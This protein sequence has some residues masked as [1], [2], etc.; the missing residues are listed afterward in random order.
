MEYS[1][2]E[3][4][5]TYFQEGRFTEKTKVKVHRIGNCWIELSAPK[6]KYDL[7]L[8]RFCLA[9]HMLLFLVM[10]FVV[11]IGFWDY[12]LPVRIPFAGFGVSLYGTW[13][14]LQEMRFM[15]VC[16]IYC[17]GTDNE[18]L[19]CFLKK[20]ERQG[21][22]KGYRL[23]SL[24]SL[25]LL[26]FFKGPYL[27]EYGVFSVAARCCER[28]PDQFEKIINEA[29]DREEVMKFIAVM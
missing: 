14:V 8:M 3:K 29:R 22:W 17:T 11:S 24:L 1:F 12:S 15:T 10:W 19:R 21:Y 18:L 9:T 2:D 13:I 25:S 4:A 23:S 27:V 28:N 7:V 6:G 26:M 5:K 20:F 16:S